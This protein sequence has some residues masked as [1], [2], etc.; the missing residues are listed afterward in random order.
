MLEPVEL[1]VA[2]A[3]ALDDEAGALYEEGAC[4]DMLALI[5][6]EMAEV[7]RVVAE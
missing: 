3:A 4:V 1:A 5:E 2:L 6:V 7:A